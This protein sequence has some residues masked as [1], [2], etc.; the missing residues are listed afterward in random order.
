MLANWHLWKVAKK[1]NFVISFMLADE[2]NSALF[3]SVVARSKA[4]VCCRSFAKI[5]GSNPASGK[6]ICL[7]RVVCCQV[8]VCTTSRSLVQRSPIECGVSEYDRR[9]SQKRPRST[10]AVEAWQ[11]K[12]MLCNVPICEV[13][14]FRDN[15]H[16]ITRFRRT[17]WKRYKRNS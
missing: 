1:C 4:W 14:C 2:Y 9:T 3:I 5:A 7:V 16:K 10:R 8:E 12:S 17:S 15:S 6:N 13:G 11:K